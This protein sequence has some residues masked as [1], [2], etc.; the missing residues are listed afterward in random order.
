MKTPA[1]PELSRRQLLRTGLTA[2][3]AAFLTSGL[4]LS[5][6]SLAR[7]QSKLTPDAALAELMAG[8]KRFTS[9]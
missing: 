8:N 1:Q 2:T 4:D 6:P 7:A 9:G 3:A 5:F